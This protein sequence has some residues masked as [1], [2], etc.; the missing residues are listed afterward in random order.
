MPFSAESILAICFVLVTLYCVLCCCISN[1]LPSTINSVL[2][3]DMP[4]V[5]IQHLGQ[6]TKLHRSQLCTS[7]V[8]LVL[9]TRAVSTGTRS[10]T[11][12][13]APHITGDPPCLSYSPKPLVSSLHYPP[14][15]RVIWRFFCCMCCGDQEDSPRSWSPEPRCKRA[16]RNDWR[17]TAR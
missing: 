11:R 12:R 14:W 4:W 15:C 16:R 8:D 13:A 10:S 9:L 7:S 2:C 3:T 6:Y 1:P 5:T 17:R